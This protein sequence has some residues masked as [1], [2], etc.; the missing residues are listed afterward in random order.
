MVDAALPALVGGT[1]I[2]T[3]LE[4]GDTGACALAT[5]GTVQCWAAAFSGTLKP[6]VITTPAPLVKIAAGGNYGCGLD[7][8]GKAWC[9]GTNTNGQLGTGDLVAHTDAVPVVGGRS[10]TS[11]TAGLIHTCALTASGEAWCW[12]NNSYYELGVGTGPTSNVPLKVSGNTTFKS[13]S[14]GGAYTCAVATDGAG[15]CWGLNTSGQLGVGNTTQQGVPTKV[16]GSLSFAMIR[17]GNGNSVNLPTCGVTTSG[18]AYCWGY[19]TVN[20]LGATTTAS[21]GFNGVDSPCAQ[22]PVRVAGLG[23]VNSIAASITHACAVTTDNKVYC[24]GEN[25][26]GQFGDGTFAVTSAAPVLVHTP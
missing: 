7:K 3:S 23:K 13:I 26:R 8:D 11:I 1:S 19:N 22:E 15:W 24:W 16:L 6:V 5:E 21:C 12:G 25:S 20:Q 9:W 17:A 2:Y 18:D 10:Y 14:A 4:V